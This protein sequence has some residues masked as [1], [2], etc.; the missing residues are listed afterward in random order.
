MTMEKNWYAVYTKNNF[1]LK[2]AAQLSKKKITNFCPLN[3][4]TD[5]GSNG[6][7]IYRFPVLTSLV[8]VHIDKVELEKIKEIKA[9]KN[10]MFWLGNPVRIPSKE[11]EQLEAFCKS[12][13]NI[14]VEKTTVNDASMLLLKKSSYVD[15]E[16]FSVS[17]KKNLITLHLPTVGL[18]LSAITDINNTVTT[19]AGLQHGLELDVT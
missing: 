13:S 5:A 8:F 1:E 12:F 7:K 16:N 18:N 14:S 9:V 10:L 3:S 19:E 4:S 6:K 2:V 15:F 11:I 17:A